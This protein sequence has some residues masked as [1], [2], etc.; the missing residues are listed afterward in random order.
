MEIN[1][2]T[3]ATYKNVV[4]DDFVIERN[5]NA[6]SEICS[7]CKTKHHLEKDKISDNA[8]ADIICG[9]Q[10][11]NNKAEYYIDFKIDSWDETLRKRS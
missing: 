5:G 1:D 9:V 6:W 10:G 11:C 4:F 2:G 7:E 3:T 8:A